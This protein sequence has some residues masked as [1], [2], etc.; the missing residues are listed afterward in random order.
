MTELQQRALAVALREHQ[1]EQCKRF[2]E[3]IEK[4]WGTLIQE[5]MAAHPSNDNKGRRLQKALNHEGK[6]LLQENIALKAKKDAGDERLPA[7]WQMLW[8]RK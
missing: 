5:S 4:L 2:P 6:K 3:S 7:M 8:R 1:E